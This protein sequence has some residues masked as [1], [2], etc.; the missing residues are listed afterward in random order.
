MTQTNILTDFFCYLGI[1]KETISE[2]KKV[3]FWA[4]INSNG[5]TV[6][7]RYRMCNPKSM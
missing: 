6:I 4:F 1:K 2:T 3:L 7:V 5:Y